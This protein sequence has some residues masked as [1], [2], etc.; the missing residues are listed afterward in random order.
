MN[1]SQQSNVFAIRQANNTCTNCRLQNICFLKG[2]ASADLQKVEKVVKHRR[3]MSCGDSL[4]DTGMPLTSLYVVRTGSIKTYRSDEQGNEQVTGFRMPGDLLG[5]DAMATDVHD[6]SAQA[7]ESAS[8]CEIPY[9]K[10]LELAATLP[11]LLRLIMREMSRE[12]V[13]EEEH[14]S[15]LGKKDA[16]ERLAAML[17]A[18]S[19]RFAARGYADG[20][21][22]LSMSRADIGNYLGLALETVSRMLSRFQERGL[23]DVRR[24]LI[25]IRD[26]ASLQKLAA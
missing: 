7:L 4:Y 12:I 21:F 11:S 22:N 19:A 18:I 8:V 2:L 24:R 10:L 25:E 20:A 13:L 6:S 23:I 17:L 3:P 1:A 16:E 9:A 14:V 15:L 5:L 26:F